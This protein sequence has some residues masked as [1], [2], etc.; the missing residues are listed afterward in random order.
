MA[1]HDVLVVLPTGA[2]KSAFYQV[3][4]LLVEGLT[5]GSDKPDVRFVTHA[6]GW[7]ASGAGS[8]PPRER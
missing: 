5:M 8:A 4:A 6:A 7:V 2:G 1:G 3:P